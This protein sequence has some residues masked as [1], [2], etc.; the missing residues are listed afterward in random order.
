VLK[1]FALC[2][3]RSVGEACGLLDELGEDAAVYAG[4]T[5][6]LL[7]MKEQLLAPNYLVDV[8]RLGLG[9]V[10]H[11]DATGEL[12]IGA[13]ATHR[14]IEVW[15]LERPEWRALAEMERGVANARVR[16]QGTI[17]GNL[18]FAEPHADPAT[19][20]S[21]WDASVELAGPRGC[22]TVAVTDF[23]ID[24]FTTALEVGEL[25]TGVVVPPLP[26]RSGSAYLK[27]GFLERPTLGVATSL[28]L[29]A[30]GETVAAARIAV[31]AVGDRP[32][33]APESEALLAAAEV[34]GA[35]WDAA[36]QAAAASAAESCEVGVDTHGSEDY[37]RHLVGVFV[38]RAL[39]LGRS[40]ALEAALWR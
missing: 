40:R 9:G 31:G 21:A 11:D 32:Q 8:K 5:E 12:R 26:P 28:A 27:F 17:G 37:K 20:L 2:E 10:S 15:A 19:L 3:P 23:L 35:A 6:L 13:T 16:N 25:M 7:A 1:H 4:G 33:R 24:E 38:R 39:E 30:D 36:V 18:C 29:S 34:H 14:E 22:R